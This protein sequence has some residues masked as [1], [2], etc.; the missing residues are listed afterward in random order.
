ML[1]IEKLSKRYAKTIA[2]DELSLVI[3][4]NGVFGIAGPNGAG[5]ST[6]VKVLAGEESQDS[7]EIRLGGQPWPLAERDWTVAVVHQEPQL[8]PNLTVL[9]NLHFGLNTKGIRLPRMTTREEEILSELDLLPFANREL[10]SCA[11]VVWQMTEISRALLREARLFLF[12]EPNSALNE[13]ESEKLFRQLRRLAEDPNH[14]VALVSH[15]LA[16]LTEHCD[17]VAI[18]REGRCTGLLAK[19]E[20]SEHAIARALVVGRPAKSDSGVRG[21][22]PAD[23]HPAVRVPTARLE[24]WTSRSNAFRDLDLTL[25]SG[26]IVAILGVEGS[27]GRELVR[28][29]SGL[30]PSEGTYEFLGRPT[31]G[32]IPA[33]VA[34]MPASRRHSLFFN[35]SIK[36]NMAARLG[37]PE[38]ANR[39]GILS[40]S[41]MGRLAEGL[42][43]RFQ[44]LTGSV[45]QAVGSLSGG[46]QQKVALAGTIATNPGLLAIEEP[47]RG[48]DIGTKAE[49]YRTLR[50]FVAE[51]N[52]VVL[53]CTEVGEIFDAA[54]VA[55][56][57]NGGRISDPIQVR[58]FSTLE[59]LAAGIAHVSQGMR[60]R[61][62]SNDQP[63]AATSAQSGI[64]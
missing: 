41:H 20:I 43:A 60:A 5:K 13:D 59:D 55:Y 18:V 10:A 40:R 33:G 50:E 54:D 62:D 58:L 45:E 42:G 19:A 14:I 12:D 35:Y 8:F 49:I 52:A 31:T 11:L 3:P 48:V 44:V 51:G 46:N 57:V 7:G 25:D 61:L 2:L 36:A 21:V 23:N 47:T 39:L 64:V 9:Q 37:H 15:R 29:L 24:R 6:L 16:D 1:E 38:I 53:Y 4:P 32:G 22:I 26:R 28:S 27:G 30:E 56:V 17:Q 63:G 34:Y